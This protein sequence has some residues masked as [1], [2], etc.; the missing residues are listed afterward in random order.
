VCYVGRGLN[1][2]TSAH[3]DDLAKLFS[4]A[5]ERGRAGALY[6]CAGSEATFRA[7]AEVVAKALGIGTRSV[8][9]EEAQGIWDKFSG[10]TVFS[11]SS[12]IR[13]IVA[14]AELG[15]AVEPG[16][17]DI[18][19]ECLHPAYLAESERTLAS[20]VKPGFASG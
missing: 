19:E 11:S 16:R 9:V 15:W 14:R 17:P 13:S 20:W 5:L 1:A 4:Q 8:T 10:T 2:Y 18:L 7:M 12:R 3:V 6:H